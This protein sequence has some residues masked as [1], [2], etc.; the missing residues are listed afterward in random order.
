M[1]S[2][3]LP[4]GSQMPVIGLG[5]W[6]A[7]D[8]KLLGS[9]MEAAF[10]AG[11]RHFDTAFAYKNEDI[12]GKVI[13]GW[14]EKGLVERKDL[15]ITTK[16]PM[17]GV[18]PDRVEL[19]LNKSLKSLRLEYV[20]LYLIHFPVCFKYEEG[21]DIVV[22]E[23]GVVQTEPTDHIAV[24]RKM[25]EMVNSGKVKHIGIS[26]F[27]RHQIA[28]ILDNAKIKPA[29]LQVEIHP[30]FQNNELVDFCK[31]KGI[32]V[33]AYSPLGSPGTN[34]FLKQSGLP[35]RDLPRLLDDETILSIA[36]KHS[37]SPA[38]IMLRFALQRG[39][40]AIPKSITA[41][42][43]KE[44]IDVFDFELDESDMNKLKKLDK[45]NE[46]RV[47]AL[48]SKGVIDHPEFPNRNELD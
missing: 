33:V 9:A 44:N 41:S 26:N 27:N 4:G 37:K 19:F 20:D 13:A 22:D 15:F 16:L 43:I 10:E 39:L 23:K 36:K 6:Q 7:K 24:W 46:G 35:S 34:I 11:Y 38:Q 5:T 3:E 42:R 45:G 14:I 29:N 17:I 18:H 40:A 31:E 12:V 21:K 8:A 28:R 25:E 32:S 48:R 30:Y 1:K 47:C 2:I